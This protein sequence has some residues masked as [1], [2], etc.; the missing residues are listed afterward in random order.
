MVRYGLAS[1]RG[2]PVAISDPNASC[3]RDGSMLG[4]CIFYNYYFN[5]FA[6]HR[7]NQSN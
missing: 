7:D 3:G 6:N 1:V 2:K 5:R 4:L